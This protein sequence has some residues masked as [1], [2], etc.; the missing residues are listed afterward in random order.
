[1]DGAFATKALHL[2]MYWGAL[3]LWGA[4]CTGCLQLAEDEPEEDAGRGHEEDEEDLPPASRLL[5]CRVMDRF[6]SSL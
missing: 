1:M 4:V 6:R 2:A 3:R 5:E